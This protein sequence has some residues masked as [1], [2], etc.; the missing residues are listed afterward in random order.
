VAETPSAAG[1]ADRQSEGRGGARDAGAAGARF[2]A[3]V[4]ILDVTEPDALT[5]RRTVEE[6]LQRAG[7]SRWWLVSLRRQAPPT[8]VLRQPQ[9][10]ARRAELSYSGGGV[11]LV[12]A[13]AAWVLWMLWLLAD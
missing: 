7:F 13:L 5:A 11:L 1:S 4:R 3:V 10:S 9:P 12:G 8:A 2:Q 6:R